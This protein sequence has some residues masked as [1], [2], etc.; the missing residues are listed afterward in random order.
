MLL[1]GNSCRKKKYWTIFNKSITHCSYWIIL[2]SWWNVIGFTHCFPS[3]CIQCIL[4]VHIEIIKLMEVILISLVFHFLVFFSFADPLLCITSMLLMWS[5]TMSWEPRPLRNMQHLR[6]I[7]SRHR[8]LLITEQ[9]ILWST[10]WLPYFLFVLTDQYDIC[11][12]LNKYRLWEISRNFDILMVALF[13]I[14]LWKKSLHTHIYIYTSM[15]CTI[16][17]YGTC[18]WLTCICTGTI[19]VK[20]VGKNYIRLRVTRL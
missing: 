18:R 11:K 12:I 1:Y 5:W 15:Q 13:I 10:N 9:F 7:F 8:F 17:V 14:S 19:C 16:M 20:I 3:V 4:F 2:F 6:S